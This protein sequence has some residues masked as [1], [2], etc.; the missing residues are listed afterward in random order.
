MYH[1]VSAGGKQPRWE[2]A[3]S[4]RQFR[5][6]MEFLAAENYCTP[7]ASEVAADPAAFI[8]RRTAVITFDDGYVDNLAACDLLQQYRMRATWFVVSGLIGRQPEWLPPGQNV[9]RLLTAPD[10]RDFVKNGME[11]GSHTVHHRRL[12]RCSETDLRQEI[13]DSKSALEDIL[14]AEVRSFAYPFGDYDARCRE[15]VRSAGYICAYTTESGWTFRDG[16]PH[17]LRR[18]T[19]FN[20]DTAGSLA[21][22]ISFGSNKVGWLDLAQYFLGRITGIQ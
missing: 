20:T 14:G 13:I 7:T 19:V 2:W 12:T 3:V 15:A 17:R 22:K 10:L 8:G 5:R 18:L 1:S 11:I 16:D 6:Q 9:P 4:M 21:R